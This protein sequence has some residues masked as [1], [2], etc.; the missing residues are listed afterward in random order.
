MSTRSSPKRT[1]PS[2][3]IG[4]VMF[5]WLAYATLQTLFMVQLLRE[6]TSALW[7]LLYE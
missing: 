2:Y 6:T 3:A 4:L 1:K 7:L 5:L